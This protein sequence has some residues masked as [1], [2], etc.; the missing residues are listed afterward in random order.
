[1]RVVSAQAQAV[2]QRVRKTRTQFKDLSRW[3]GFF[4][5]GAVGLS[6]GIAYILTHLYR[7][8]PFPGF[9]YY[10]TLQFISRPVRGVLFIAWGCLIIAI[11]VRSLYRSA[12]GRLSGRRE[13]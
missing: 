11:G 13:E 5:L 1:M 8:Q 4:V 9:V 12:G 7:E 2:Q 6:L 10:L 3:L